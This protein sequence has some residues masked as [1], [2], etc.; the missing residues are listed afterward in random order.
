M[1]Q[2]RDLSPTPGQV[3]LTQLLAQ[4]LERQR[5][6]H[7]SG[8]T[9]PE[10]AGEVELYDAGPAQAVEPRLAWDEAAAVLRHFHPGPVRAGKTPPEWPLL[11]ASHEP[12]AALAFAA[13][14]FP[15][16]VRDLHAL[17]HTTDRKA[18]RPTLGRSVAVPALLDWAGATL[19]QHQFPQSLLALGALRLAK[20]FDH[21]AK[22]VEQEKA[23][24]PVD[25][26]AAWANEEAALAWHRGR[27]EEAAA[28]WQ[29]QEGSI[30]VLFNRGMAA[31]F[32]DQPGQ[33]REALRKATEQLPDSG[34]WHHLGRLYLGLTDMRV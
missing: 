9:L 16:L 19:R 22:L 5:T 28:L 21:A 4:Y 17:L 31:L 15:Q 20:Q 24:V 7:A 12:V 25:W 27:H 26:R 34:A 33:A 11:V 2:P 13:G 3:P 1:T 6:A 18:L 14:N 8:L 30:P 32:L 29:A 10:V 23:A